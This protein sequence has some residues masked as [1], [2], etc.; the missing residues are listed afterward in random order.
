MSISR[1]GNSTLTRLGKFISGSNKKPPEAASGGGKGSSASQG[2][3]RLV[4]RGQGKRSGLVLSEQN[5]LD[6]VRS[7]VPDLLEGQAYILHEGLENLFQ[8]RPGSFDQFGEPLEGI[9]D[10]FGFSVF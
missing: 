3:N 7:Q 4:G 5:P 9:G 6:L 10:S 2:E 1:L 8:S